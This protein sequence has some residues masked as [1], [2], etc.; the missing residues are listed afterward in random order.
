MSDGWIQYVASKLNEA[1]KTQI[2]EMIIDNPNLISKYVSAVD[3]IQGEIN[4][5]KLG[6]Y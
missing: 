2:A 1:G 3:K 4:F 5:L 6:N